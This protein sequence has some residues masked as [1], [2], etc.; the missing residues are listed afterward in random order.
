MKKVLFITNVAVPFR[1]E[2]FNELGKMTDLTVVFEAEYAEKVKY[3]W[4]FSVINNFNP[5]FL[6]KGKINEKRIN[7]KIFKV[8]NNN[9]DVIILSGYSSISA[10]LLILYLKLLRRKYYL[11]VDGGLIKNDSIIIKQIKKLMI[12][13]AFGY[14]SPSSNVDDYLI[15]YGA[16]SNRIFRYPFSSLNN[17]DIL[18][19]SIS[20]IEKNQIK[21]ELGLNE[22]KVILSVGQFIHRK[23][24]DILIKAFSELDENYVLC[25]VGGKPNDEYNKLISQLKVK[26]IKFISYKSKEDLYKYYYA[27]DVF[28]LATRE[29]IWGL[30]INEAMG[31]GL[32]IITTDKCVAG[33]ELVKNNVNGYIIP[34]DSISTLRDKLKLILDSDDLRHSMNKESLKIIKNYTIENMSKVHFNV[35]VQEENN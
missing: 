25:I 33:L 7:F 18:K 1:L 34:V 27:A 19:N 31:A 29:D 30:V 24:M 32:P 20:E 22:H 12:K 28:A 13:G 14:F 6:K 2:F 23:G 26:N 11:E 5:V 8:I 3:N 4:D 9:Y 15:Y 16:N 21:K 17:S 10:K 35:I